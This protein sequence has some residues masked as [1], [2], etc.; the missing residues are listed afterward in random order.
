MTHDNHQR[1]VQDGDVFLKRALAIAIVKKRKEQ[2][3]EVKVCSLSQICQQPASSVEPPEDVF[4]EPFRSFEAFVMS[5]VAINACFQSKLLHHP[6]YGSLSLSQKWRSLAASL[7][8]EIGQIKQQ[9]DHFQLQLEER[10]TLSSS[11]AQ[12]VHQAGNVPAQYSRNQE[13]AQ[14][15]AELFKQQAVD[16][17]SSILLSPD[18]FK[19]GFS[20]VCAAQLGPLAAETD[21]I[22][23]TGMT[24]DAC[25]FLM[26]VRSIQLATQVCSTSDCNI[27]CIPV[28]C[29][30]VLPLLQ[31]TL[32]VPCCREHI[33]ICKDNL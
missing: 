9:R 1:I 27:A 19:E 5:Y 4:L 25:R 7:E 20:E 6:S 21:R 24:H 28:Q 17:T 23:S 18:A 22:L 14:A 15:H 31:E 13:S 8:D 33:A 26:E 30:Y 11:S 16:L 2:D 32:Y 3:L 29:A 10:K 12:N